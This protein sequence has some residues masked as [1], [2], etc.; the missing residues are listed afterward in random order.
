MAR[1]GLGVSSAERHETGALPQ[2]FADTFGWEALADARRAFVRTL[3]P[4]GTRRPAS[5]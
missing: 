1:L 4:E 3:P 5:T 2:H